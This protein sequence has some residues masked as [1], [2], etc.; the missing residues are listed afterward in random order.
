MYLLLNVI[1]ALDGKTLRFNFKEICLHLLILA[2]LFYSSFIIDV[3]DKLW[4][5]LQ[6][7]PEIFVV[8]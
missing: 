6:P 3:W 2:T 1:S 4:V 8:I 5:M 7:V